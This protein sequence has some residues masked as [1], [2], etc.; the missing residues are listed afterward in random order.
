MT[1]FFFSVAS[2]LLFVVV[3]FKF[4]TH[5]VAEVGNSYQL[6][7]FAAGVQFPGQPRSIKNLLSSDLYLDAITKMV[8][9][10]EASEVLKCL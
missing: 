9:T 3:C 8:K 5:I 6:F 7:F 1:S 2:D 10:T 4:L